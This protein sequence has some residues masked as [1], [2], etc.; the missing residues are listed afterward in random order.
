MKLDVLHKILVDLGIVLV[1]SAAAYLL[2]E[3]MHKAPSAPQTQFAPA[4]Q[5]KEVQS[6]K[7]ITIPG[8]TRIVTI[9]KPVVVHDLK[10]PDAIAA[11]PD[12]QTTATAQVENADK[13]KVDAISV[14]DT[15]TGVTEIETKTEARPWFSFECEK[16]IGI[17]GGIGL[18]GISGSIYGQ[19]SFMRTGNVHYAL[20]GEA[21]SPSF[22]GTPVLNQSTAAQGDAKLQLRIFYRW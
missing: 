8:P 21:D 10:L 20:Y 11:D 15:K 14:M 3:D 17:G 6:V 13:S 7:T 2:V 16:E 22:M 12:K 19:I 18:R 1:M 4:P 5:I 9:D